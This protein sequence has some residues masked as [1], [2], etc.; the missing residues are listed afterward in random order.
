MTKLRVYIDKIL[1]GYIIQMTKNGKV[2][3]FNQSDFSTG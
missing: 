2:Y 1:D 3:Y